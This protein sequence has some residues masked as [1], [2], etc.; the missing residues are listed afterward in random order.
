MEL[1]PPLLLAGG[2][3]PLEGEAARGQA[4]HRQ[5]VHGGAAAGDGQHLHAVFGAQAHQILAG[6]ADGGH[7]RVGHQGAGLASQQAGQDGLSG[8]GA[9]VLV[10]ADQGLFDVEVVQQLHRHAGILGGDE[11]G[12]LQRFH[13]AG[14]EIPQVADGGGDQI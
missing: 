5:S 10:I 14:G 4:G 3:E 13:G 12:A 9:V 11:V 8:G 2:Q 6:V 1:L 7:A